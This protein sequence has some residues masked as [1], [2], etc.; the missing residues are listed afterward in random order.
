M[1]GGNWQVMVLSIIQGVE[2][3]SPWGT[4]SNTCSLYGK[5]PPEMGIFPTCR[6]QVWKREGILQFEVYERVGKSII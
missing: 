4:H 1:R 5:A 2:Q 3:V 6:L